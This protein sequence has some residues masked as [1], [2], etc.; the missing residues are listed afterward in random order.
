MVKRWLN[1]RGPALTGAPN[2]HWVKYEDYLALQAALREA[3]D[4]WD[5]WNKDQLEGSRG[6][7]GSGGEADKRI[8]TLR[9]EFLDV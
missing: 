6:W 1:D 3:L 9:K 7:I 2:G 8:K 4:Q 5:G